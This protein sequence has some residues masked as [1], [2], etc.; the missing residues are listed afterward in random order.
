MNEEKRPDAELAGARDRRKLLVDTSTYSATLVVTQLIGLIRGVI[1]AAALGP[2]SYGVWTA[3]SY[4]VSYSPYSN[5]GMFTGMFREAAFSHGRGDSDRVDR[6]RDTAFSFGMTMAFLVSVGLVLIALFATQLSTTVRIGLLSMALATLFDRY[7]WFFLI[8]FRLE[9]RNTEVSLATGL[10]AL[11]Y[12]VLALSLISKLG[13]YALL[14]SLPLSTIPASIFLRHRA[15]KR[16]HLRLDHK[17]LRAIV[18]VGLP[19]DMIGLLETLGQTAGGLIALLFLD[20][21][22]VGFYGIS[23]VAVTFLVQVPTAISWTT[24]PYLLERYGETGNVHSVHSHSIGLTKIVALVMPFLIGLAILGLPLVLHHAL[25]RFLPGLDMMRIM[26]CAS[27]FFSINFVAANFL[28]A[29]ERQ[30]HYAYMR[31]ASTAVNLLSVAALLALGFGREGIALGYGASGLVLATALVTYM[32]RFFVSGWNVPRFVA[33]AYAP[34]LY[35]ILAILALIQLVGTPTGTSLVE[36]SIK[37]TIAVTLFALLYAPLLY[38]ADR[39]IHLTRSVR[40]KFKSLRR[41]E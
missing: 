10:A 15:E 33:K 38:M 36:D 1:V 4:I 16:F 25:P 12:T 19:L 32:I 24:N 3:L 9:K 7:F 11:V 41:K 14:I 20:P 8:A 18:R 6:V 22:D 35:A 40:E 5:L 39:E 34:L 28:V 27:F 2:S 29:L 13:I 26:L 21:R 23:L 37:T 17:V 30:K 31:M